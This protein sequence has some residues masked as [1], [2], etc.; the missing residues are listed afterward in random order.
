MGSWTHVIFDPGDH[1]IEIVRESL[2]ATVNDTVTEERYGNLVWRVPDDFNHER[3]A[4]LEVAAERVLVVYLSNTSDAGTGYLYER[5]NDRFVLTDRISGVS[6]F[7]GR[8]VVDY[9]IREHD[10]VGFTP[11]NIVREV[12]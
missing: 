8:D 6:P 3:V 11:R 5:H 7:V 4:D 9:F 2:Q 1:T 12:P 10:F